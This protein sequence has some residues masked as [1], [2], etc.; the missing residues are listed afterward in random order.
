MKPVKHSS[1]SFEEKMVPARVGVRLMGVFRSLLRKINGS[2]YQTGDQKT[3]SYETQPSPFHA[4]SNRLGRRH[5]LLVE[6][7]QAIELLLGLGDAKS[8]PDPRQ[9]WIAINLEDE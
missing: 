3:G 1:E 4:K 5:A 2:F 7:T 6:V 8:G 9:E